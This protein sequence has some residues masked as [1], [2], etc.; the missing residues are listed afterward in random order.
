VYDRASNSILSSMEVW[1]SSHLM[2]SVQ[3]AAVDS[4]NSRRGLVVGL[5][6]KAYIRT[7]WLFSYYFVDFDNENVDRWKTFYTQLAL[8]LSLQPTH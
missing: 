5:F 7:Q 8:Q 3:V 1:K 6:G 4:F 2:S